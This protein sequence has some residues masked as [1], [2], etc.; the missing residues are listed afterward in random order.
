MEPEIH[1]CTTRDGISIAY[2]VIGSGPPLVAVGD[3][4]MSHLSATWRVFGRPPLAA[5][6]TVVRYDGRG[7]GL[8]EREP[9]DFSL[10]E[11][12][13]DL[14]AIIERTQTGRF[15]LSA[16][17]GGG[18]PAIAYAAGN[19]DRVSSL[20]LANAYASGA[21]FYQETPAARFIAALGEVTQDQ[22]EFVTLAR[23]NRMMGG[24][25]PGRARQVAELLR[26]AMTP[27]ALLKFRDATQRIDVTPLL[28]KVS[29]PTLV[30]HWQTGQIPLSLSRELASGIPGAR[31]VVIETPQGGDADVRTI[32]DFLGVPTESAP[33]PAVLPSG[34]AVILFADIAGST[35]LTER[36]GD[37][38]FRAKARELDSALRGVIRECAGTPV[39]G[40]TMGDGVLATFT[41]AREAIEAARRCGKAGDDDGLPLHLGL[42]AGD[43]TREK[44]PDGRANVYGGAVNIAARI[45]GLSAPG[46]VLV[47]DVVRTLARTSAG[48]R[49]EDRGEQ[50]LKG[51]GEAVRVWAV[52][53]GE[54]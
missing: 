20:V 29:V 34:T 32:K 48:V 44:D 15:A 19:P 14:E 30:L 7:G 16:S 45:S 6:F 54:A 52:R 27:E 22:W 36:F 23:A 1:Y 35:A 21:R 28:A 46:E 39:E 40:P 25:D 33:S 31:I 2:Q 53:E 47:S 12:V 37:A 3:A 26:A 38:A 18:L 42:H 8:S 10:R 49:F 50:T 5:D 4:S 13:V 24:A 41:S 11:R 9:A 51:V 43:V 17:L